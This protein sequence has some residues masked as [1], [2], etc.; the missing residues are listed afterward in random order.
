MFR[1]PLGM[2]II[3]KKQNDKW[4]TRFIE[5]AKTVAEWS[6]DPSTKVGAIL[7]DSDRNIRCVGYNGFPR[8]IE[9]SPERLYNRDLKYQLTVHAEQNLLNTCARIGIPTSGCTLVCTHLP[10]VS[11]SGSIIQAGI[12]KVIVKAP[13]KDFLSRWKDSI[14]LAQTMFEESDVEVLL[15]H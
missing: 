2:V 3:M 9:D 15:L 7:V 1:Y 4:E 6:H 14:E 8:G 12:K 10:C 11:C 5:L 13:S